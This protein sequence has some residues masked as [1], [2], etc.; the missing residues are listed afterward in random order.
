MAGPNTSNMSLRNRAEPDS[1]IETYLPARP[2]PAGPTHVYNKQ[3]S[4]VDLAAGEGSIFR[5]RFDRPGNYLARLGQSDF[6]LPDPTPNG[7]LTY[8]PRLEPVNPADT[9]L[10]PPTALRLCLPDFASCG[11]PS[12][13]HAD[14]FDYHA[15]G[16]DVE[17]GELG[18]CHRCS[19]L[20]LRA[21]IHPLPCG[22]LLCSSCLSLVAIN[23]VATAHSDNH[24]VRRPIREAAGELG[25]LRR[26]LAPPGMR[27]L[28]ATQEARMARYRARLLEH[29]GLSCCG[30]DMHLVEDWILC[31]DQWVARRL[32][33]VTW[34][35]FR[36][37]GQYGVMW[38]GWRD[39]RAAIPSWCSY[40]NDDGERRW[41]CVA[42]KG[43]SMCHGQGFLGPAR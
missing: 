10:P 35:L 27:A 30:R 16:D 12:C 24:L 4:P 19:V 14:R 15:N 37:E 3:L 28:R 9:P 7:P 11:R 23:A 6:K 41:Y 29:L 36:G 32:W 31:L 17:E 33:A 39:C 13:S 40:R 34:R 8:D 21:E 18:E 5:R 22:H 25:R 42:C 20:E 1:P 38:C 2:W 26:D 43:N